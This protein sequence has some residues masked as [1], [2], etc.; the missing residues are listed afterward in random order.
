MTDSGATILN[1]TPGATSRH[2]REIIEA[3]SPECLAPPLALL[4]DEL[5]RVG[6]TRSAATAH[7]SEYLQILGVR[8]ARQAET[9]RKY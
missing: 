6:F 3:F 5:I 8:M 4:I 7:V 9:K 2:A 1:F